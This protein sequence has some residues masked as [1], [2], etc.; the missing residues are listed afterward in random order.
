MIPDARRKL[1]AESQKM[2]HLIKPSDKYKLYNLMGLR[3]DN[4]FLAC[5]IQALALE[6]IRKLFHTYVS[7][8]RAW[9]G[10]FNHNEKTLRL[11][12]IRRV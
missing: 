2:A 12:I 9:T 7:S 6:Q 5:E 1:V 4:D 3:G 10:I 8:W 11:V